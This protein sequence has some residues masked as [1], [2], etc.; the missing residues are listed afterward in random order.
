MKN[1]QPRTMLGVGISIIFVLS[2]PHNNP[3]F[4]TLVVFIHQCN[5]QCSN[6]APTYHVI[7]TNDH[8]ESSPKLK[9]LRHNF[10]R[11]TTNMRSWKICTCLSLGKME[12]QHLSLS[13]SGNMEKQAIY[14]NPSLLTIKRTQ[15]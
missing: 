15:A 8:T 5:S 11:I 6:L 10:I 3:M 2:T 14:S 12:S 4:S 9:C 13:H 1:H 7:I